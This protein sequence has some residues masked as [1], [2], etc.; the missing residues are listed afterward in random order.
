VQQQP[1]ALHV[2]QEQRAQACA[3]RRS[4]N[5]SGDVGDHE[6]AE[7][8]DADHAQVR[9]QRGERVVRHLRRGRGHGAHEGALARVREAEQADVGE[10]LQLQP[11]VALLALGAGGGLA[12]RAVERALEVHVALAA[13][14][15]AGDQQ[16]L[17]VLHQVADDLVGGD[18]HHLGAD[19]HA[20]HHVLAGL[21]VHLA[22]HAVLAALGAELALVAEVDQRVEVL[23]GHQPDAAAVAAVAAVRAAE[24]DELLAPEAHAPVAAVAGEHGDHCLVDELHGCIL[25]RGWRKRKAPP[26]R[27]PSRG[28]VAALTRP[29]R[30]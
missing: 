13:V 16:A 30:R 12:R 1:R 24:R 18:V 3:L 22:A 11:D 14:A 27:G 7:C 29:G 21:A 10:Q 9:V 4:F 28:D 5:D 15:A 19:R 25:L 23:V 17:A 20:D 26:R 2:A 6:A 8:F